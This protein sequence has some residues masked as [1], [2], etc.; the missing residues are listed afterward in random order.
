[1]A[2]RGG[3]AGWVAVGAAAGGV[4]VWAVLRF[5]VLRW[6]VDEGHPARPVVEGLSWIAGIGGLV[7]AV[8]ALVV[9]VRQQRPVGEAGGGGSGG[10]QSA[11]HGGVILN[12]GVRGGSGSGL[13]VGVQVNPPDPPGPARG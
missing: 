10:A 3:R 8:A 13:T 1:M 6:L 11:S 4:A 2:G 9:A 5:G 12:N 7:V